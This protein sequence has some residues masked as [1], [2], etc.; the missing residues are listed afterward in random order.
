MTDD[1]EFEGH[2]HLDIHAARALRDLLSY[3]IEKWPG[4]PARPAEEQEFARM[5]LSTVNQIILEHNFNFL[6]QK[7]D[8]GSKET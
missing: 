2:L 6:E 1:Q 4:S 3:F 8:R 7:D 5:L